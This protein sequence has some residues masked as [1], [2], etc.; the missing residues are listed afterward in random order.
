MAHDHKARIT[1]RIQTYPRPKYWA[2]FEADRVFKG[3]DNTPMGKS[4]LA[5]DILESHYRNKPEGEQ[6]RLL[7]KY[8]EMS[9]Q[10]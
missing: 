3:M 4:E 1:H 6:Q 9:R 5:N 2:M 10:K 7:N 8:A